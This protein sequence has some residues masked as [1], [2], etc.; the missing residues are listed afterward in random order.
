MKKIIPGFLLFIITIACNDP[1]AEML[2]N[3]GKDWPDPID[4]GEITLCG[5]LVSY[6]ML[7]DSI[8]ANQ[9]HKLKMWVDD[10]IVPADIRLVFPDMEPDS[11]FVPKGGRFA[12]YLACP[13]E[14]EHFLYMTLY[15][16]RYN[17]ITN[18]IE[19]FFVVPCPDSPG[20]PKIVGIDVTHNWTP[21]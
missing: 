6:Y 10:D 9:P 16:L 4:A 12:V 19:R 1:Y 5:A 13:E 7:E 20:P 15:N 18:R 2:A 14:G 3:R 21:K 11:S 8:S 17:N